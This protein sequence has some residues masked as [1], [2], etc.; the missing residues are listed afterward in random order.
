MGTDRPTVLVVD[1]DRELAD[2][3]AAWLTDTYDV[4]VTYSGTEALDTLDSNVDVVLLDRL[5]PG[6]S[7]DE[8]VSSAHEQGYDCP[9]AMVTA[10]RPDFDILELGFDEYIVKPIR[11]EELHDIVDSLLSRATYDVQLQELYSLV[12]KRAVLEAEKRRFE[13]ER[14]PAYHELTARIHRL[15]TELDETTS[16]LTERDFE[17]ELRK[18]GIGTCV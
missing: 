5:M 14:E 3:Y 11:Y 16:K 15:E 7:G 9:V 13:L 8:V 18:I 17:V 6:V 2:L 4:R 12:S 1:D 10:V